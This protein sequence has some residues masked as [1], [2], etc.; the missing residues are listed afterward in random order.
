MKSNLVNY[1][2]VVILKVNNVFLQLSN[3]E[4]TYQKVQSFRVPCGKK[5]DRFRIIGRC[6]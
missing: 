1:T 5:K 4:Q 6:S 2:F 3:K